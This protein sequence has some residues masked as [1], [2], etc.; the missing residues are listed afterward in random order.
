MRLSF[1]DWNSCECDM[2]RVK[3][4][5]LQET[6]VFIVDHHVKKL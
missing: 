5:S 4:R 2:M 1:K 3:S 6:N